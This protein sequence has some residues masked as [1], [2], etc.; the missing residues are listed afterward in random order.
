MGYLIG[1]TLWYSNM[2]GFEIPH[3][4]QCHNFPAIQFEIFQPTTV[5]SAK[6][7]GFV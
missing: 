1:F 3:L 2:A 4:D 5:D 7:G 6:N